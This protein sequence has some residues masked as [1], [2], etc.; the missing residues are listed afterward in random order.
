[1]IE[2]LSK[3]K[4]LKISSYI[5]FLIYI[6][7]GNSTV[8]S[9]N[10]KINTNEL[11]NL[12][13]LEKKIEN[14]Y[15]I[16]PG[17]I[18]EI[19]ASRIVSSGQSSYSVDGNGTINLPNLNRIYVEGLTINELTNLLN[20][21][22]N[23]FIISPSVEINV[24]A[25]RPIRIVVNGEVESPGV[26]TLLGSIA[27]NKNSLSF[28]NS[29]NQN[30]EDILQDRASSYLN[31]SNN[32]TPFQSNFNNQ[33]QSTLIDSNTIN[34]FSTNDSNL[35]KINPELNF[36]P[37]IFDAI[38]KADGVTFYS[39][40]TKVKVT[41]INSI[42][43][44][45]DRIQTTIN[46]LDVIK[47]G[48]SKKNI[49]IYDGDVITIAKT[50]VPI[51]GQISSAVLSNLNPKY[52]PVFVTGRVIAP[53]SHTVSKKSALNDA[54][55]IAGGTK[56]IKGPVTFI[57]YNQDGSLDQR[58]FRINKRKKRGSYKN[59]YLKSGDIIFVGNSP[60][61]IASDLLTEVTRPFIGIYGTYNLFSN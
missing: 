58:K 17:D 26:H 50:D 13:Y 30:Q 3:N 14:D 22:Y 57:R 4:F 44:G 21:R 18:L 2:R 11:P 39:D 43:N 41:R 54:I 5:L 59:P 51:S 15:I 6:L 31:R 53:G 10:K 47:N 52:I 28:N 1:M 19:I 34:N 37:T 46:F 36:F 45:G 27:F 35:N 60:F 24:L 25:Y 29:I 20:E 7:I 56:I 55:A 40:L 61:N 33:L 16:G 12:N 48:D 8:R 32:S 23:E 9:E 42:S 49:R 38:K